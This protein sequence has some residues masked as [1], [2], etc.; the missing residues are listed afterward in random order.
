MSNE[1]KEKRDKY[2][3]KRNRLICFQL[4]VIGTLAVILSFFVIKYIRSNKEYNLEYNESMTVDYKVY[5]K[6]NSFYEEDYL[7]MGQS[8][9]TELIDYIDLDLAYL[10]KFAES[11]KFKFSYEIEAFLEINNGNSGESNLLYR[12]KNADDQINLKVANQQNS[13]KELKV[14]QSVRI[15]FNAYNDLA[16]EYIKTYKP[17]NANSTLI[18]KFILDDEINCTKLNSKG[19]SKSTIS[20]KIPLTVNTM[21]IDVTGLNQINGTKY[22]TCL[23]QNNNN[24]NKYLIIGISGLEVVLVIV[25]IIYVLSTKNH[26]INYEIKIKRIMN[27]YKSFIQRV[28]NDFNEDGYQVLNINSIKE[29][30]ELRDT[31][32]MPILMYENEDK[33]YSKFFLPTLN[34]VLYKF[35]VKV[36]NYDELYKTQEQTIDA[37]VNEE[38]EDIE[39]E[40]VDA[41]IDERIETEE[42][43]E[44]IEENIEAEEV[45]EEIKENIEAEEVDEEIEENIETEEVDEDIE[46][47]EVADED[48][49]V[50]DEDFEDDDEEEDFEDYEDSFNGTSERY[51]YSFESK[52]ILAPAE[53]KEFYLKIVAHVKSYGVK[54]M[55]SWDKERI[56]IGRKTYGVICFSGKSLFVGL[57]LNPNDETLK[58]YRLISKEHV[59]KHQQYPAFVRVTS[60][61]KVKYVIELLEKVFKDNNIE[62]KKLSVKV[63]SIKTKTR[64]ALI[65]EGLIR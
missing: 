41:K 39:T 21:K 60:N 23:N 17:V 5:L 64:A 9:I 51:N 34:H 49:E 40:E 59:K 25:L 38:I 24:L 36:D 2:R 13:G 18:I 15:D 20:V 28:L 12:Y 44:E 4:V 10:V 53:T 54:L 52:L 11:V 22:I 35:E 62:N 8:Y 48:I 47:K 26:D 50:I 61:R 6:E 14:N 58:K 37:I 29:M 46:N 31:L 65:E 7:P 57:P 56:Y 55:R 27:N 63:D 19:T 3:Q 43:D 33:T 32:Q 16:T 42:V 30:L 45:D 1:Q